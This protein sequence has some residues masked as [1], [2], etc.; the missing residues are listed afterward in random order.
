MRPSR[1]RK[2]TP[3]VAGSSRVDKGKGRADPPRVSPRNHSQRRTRASVKGVQKT[4]PD[5]P[6]CRGRP[7]KIRK[8]HCYLFLSLFDLI[9][10]S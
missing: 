2:D 9:L 3:P 10:G 6:K 7:P 1:F 8:S 5:P 4:T